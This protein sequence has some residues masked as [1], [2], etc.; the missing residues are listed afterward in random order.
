MAQANNPLAN[1]TALNF[2]VIRRTTRIF[3]QNGFSKVCKLVN[4]GR[5]RNDT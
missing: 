3:A 2:H 4:R 1:F 5:Y